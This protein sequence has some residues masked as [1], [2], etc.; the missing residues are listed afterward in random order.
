MIKLKVIHDKSLASK[1]KYYSNLSQ[2]EKG[3]WQTIPT[4]APCILKIVLPNCILI[5]CKPT[6]ERVPK[7]LPNN[8]KLSVNKKKQSS[9]NNNNTEEHQCS[10]KE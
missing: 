5:Y 9:K 3:I 8:R 4:A 6:E 7:I 1:I 2:N 10:S